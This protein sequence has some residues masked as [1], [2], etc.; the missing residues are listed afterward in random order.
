MN[1]TIKNL[2]VSVYLLPTLLMGKN[3]LACGIDPML[4]SMCV[5]A[6]NFAPRGY[7]LAE[8]QLLAINQNQALYS[9]LGTTYGGDGRT[10]FGLPD[11]RGRALIG[12]G[13]GPGLSRYTLGQRGAG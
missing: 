10:T 2:A 1:N 7:A 6:G 9:L 8:G 5:F 12:V 3:A 11:A 4:A 13:T